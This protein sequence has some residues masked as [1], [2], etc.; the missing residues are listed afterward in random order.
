MRSYKLLLVV[1]YEEHKYL[2]VIPALRHV[3]IFPILLIVKPESKPID[4]IKGADRP[5]VIVSVALDVVYGQPER[6]EHLSERGT[7]A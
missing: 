5:G 3:V 1:M 4:T 2:E 6:C 7:R